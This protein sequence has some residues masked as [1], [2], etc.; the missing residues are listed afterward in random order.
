MLS[1]VGLIRPSRRRGF[2]PACRLFQIG[3]GPQEIA[4]PALIA[5]AF[6]VVAVLAWALTI[7]RWSSM[8]GTAMGFGPVDQFIASWAVMMAAMMLPSAMPLVFDFARNSERR[9]GWP[10][11]TVLL[12][13]TYLGVW[14]AFGVVCYA[15]YEAL[16]MPWANQA[17]VAGAA[18][19]VAGVYGLTPLKRASEALCRERCALHGPLPFDLMRSAVVVGLRYGMSCL[20]CTAGLMVAMVLIG[21]SDLAWMIVLAGVVLAYKLGPAPTLRATLALSAAMIV[22]G[23]LYATG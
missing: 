20:G 11:A 16:G 14:L 17:F 13:A 7:A 8:D 18:L 12:G 9:R 22:L 6:L 19:V 1:A 15:L 2:C 4:A 23:M 10:A 5:V 21:M 3:D